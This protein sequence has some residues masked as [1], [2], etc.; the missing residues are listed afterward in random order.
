M[1]FPS[2]REDPEMRPLIIFATVLSQGALLLP[3]A[4]P[5][6][7]PMASLT[8]QR[9]TVVK[10]RVQPF[11]RSGE[12]VAGFYVGSDQQNGYFITTFHSLRKVSDGHDPV[13]KVELWFNTGPTPVWAA[14]LDRFNEEDDLAV[15]YVPIAKLPPGLMPP[16]R[17]DPSAELPVHIIGHPAGGDWT[18]WTGRIQNEEVAAGDSRYFAT[19]SDS[20]LTFGFSGG[21]VFDSGGEF[22]GMHTGST[23]SYGKALKS[24]I[25][26]EE[27]TSWHVPTTD[28]HTSMD[29]NQSQGLSEV[30]G[31]AKTRPVGVEPPNKG[32]VV[33]TGCP[34]GTRAIVDGEGWEALASD[35]KLSM[36]SLQF[37]TH[38]VQLVHKGYIARNLDAVA[39]TFQT[40]EYP[41]ALRP[42]LEGDWDYPLSGFTSTMNRW[43][44]LSRLD[45]GVTVGRVTVD[46]PDLGTGELIIPVS[47]TPYF[48]N[49]APCRFRL[50]IK[51]NTEQSKVSVA[52]EE[53]R[54]G[55]AAMISLTPNEDVTELTGKA[56]DLVDGSIT[57]VALKRHPQH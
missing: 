26:I 19:T 29:P 38:K 35:G 52:L 20:S 3:V 37:G 33:F 27:L 40:N 51:Y 56:T 39:G 18:S 36:E 21:P 16:T 48:T 43:C 17:K 31:H 12:T 10:L 46:S 45:K 15:V 7:S 32:R 30:D 1:L 24:R 41:C 34:N 28:S 54:R 53:E 2:E 49:I 6:Q 13:D 9:M 25:I 14:V 22:I 23:S 4:V 8:N 55:A 5:G 50:T 47:Q 44:S 11:R 42:Q 57:Q